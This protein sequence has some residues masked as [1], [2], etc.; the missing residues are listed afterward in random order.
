MRFSQTSLS[1]CI[2]VSLNSV[3][4]TASSFPPTAKY[5]FFDVGFDTYATSINL[6]EDVVGYSNNNGMIRA[7][8]RKH[9]GKIL[10]FDVPG[11][12][13]SMATSIN[14]DGTIVGFGEDGYHSAGFVR[15]PDGSV[16]VFALGD[17]GTIP[18]SVNDSG[19]VA[20]FYHTSDGRAHGF[21]RTSDGTVKTIDPPDSY[22][23]LIYDIN[24]QG[25]VAG[26]YY[27]NAGGVHGFMQAADDTITIFD[28]PGASQTAAKSINNEGWVAGEYYIEADGWQ[29]FVRDP[30]GA[31]TTFSGKHGATVVNCINSR[32]KVAGSAFTGGFVF[33]SGSLLVFHVPAGETHKSKTEAGCLNDHGAVV[34][35]YWSNQEERRIGFVRNP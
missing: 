10:E 27:A 34:G 32:E 7:F 12:P 19:V 6:Q 20:G 14:G 25:A 21:T 28:V 8:L 23:T 35:D 3:S 33:K 11:F 17:D 30:A 13:E 24:D 31:L 22:D 15:T 16:T 9:S 4:A 26:R 5:E 29:G 18:E 1:M 2:F